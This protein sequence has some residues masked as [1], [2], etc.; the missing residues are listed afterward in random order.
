MKKHLWMA[1][2][3]CLLSL[4]S[5]A[6]LEIPYESRTPI[7]VMDFKAGVGVEQNEVNGLSD[8]LINSLYKT[9]E[10]RI[11]ERSQLNQVLKEQ[12]FQ[13]SDL[14]SEQVVEIGKIL[15][16]KSILIGSVNFI[17]TGRTLYQKAAGT[18]SGEYNVDIRVVDCTTGELMT[19]AGGT[20]TSGSTYRKLMEKISEE[21]AENFVT[22]E[23][24]E[25]KQKRKGMGHIIMKESLSTL[26]VGVVFLIGLGLVFM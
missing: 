22:P 6:T 16:V 25:V 20:K 17:P 1:A 21:L 10:F 9:G 11:I 7:A 2:A 3:V 26:G 8:M 15:G 19:T 12:N 4:A 5:C 24:L 14:T 18:V 13:Q 23:E